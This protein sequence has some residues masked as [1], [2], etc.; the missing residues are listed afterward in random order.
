MDATKRLNVL[1]DDFEMKSDTNKVIW[2]CENE[3]ATYLLLG[4]SEHRIQLFHHVSA[5]GL[6]HEI[7][8]K[9]SPKGIIYCIIVSFSQSVI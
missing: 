9:S 8:V 2:S 6:S 3:S 1:R 4:A 7:F 5:L